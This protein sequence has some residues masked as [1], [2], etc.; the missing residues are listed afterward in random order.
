[1]RSRV[2]AC[3]RH[4]TGAY[5]R[6]HQNSVSSATR[7]S[8]RATF[9]EL[10]RGALAAQDLDGYLGRR[11]AHR[12]VLPD[13]RAL[14]P[15]GPPPCRHAS[16]RTLLRGPRPDRR[17]L[18]LPSRHPQ[19]RAH[20]AAHDA[21]RGDPWIVSAGRRRR[22]RDRR[23][24]VAEA[25]PTDMAGEAERIVEP[26]LVVDRML[27]GPFRAGCTS[28]ASRISGA[29]STRLTD[30]VD[31]HLPLG[32]LGSAADAL[33][34]R[35][36]AGPHVRA[37]ASRKPRAAR[38]R[39]GRKESGMRPRT[40]F[41]PDSHRVF[42]DP[43]TGPWKDP[44][45]VAADPLPTLLLE[46]APARAPVAAAGRPARRPA[47]LPGVR[48][49]GR[50]DGNARSALGV[51]QRGASPAD[52]LEQTVLELAEGVAEL[53]PLTSPDAGLG[54]SATVVAVR[55][56]EVAPPGARER[57]AGATPARS[58]HCKR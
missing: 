24:A 56:T 55:R 33:L 45:D 2:A 31:Y 1:M 47:P 5:V 58:R 9:C 25:V 6:S 16:L 18:R 43:C 28:T 15:G 57:E 50:R 17:R 54:A 4:S 46:A 19:R 51:A 37:S 34:V 8:A 52:R 53:E 44:T 29:G 39:Q 38:G 11:C 41:S 20:L 23:P 14:R 36:H 7:P 49:H 32:P 3:N 22:G 42:T 27:P 21:D 26:T 10:P 13:R 48:G 12:R 30:H 35:Q 40:R